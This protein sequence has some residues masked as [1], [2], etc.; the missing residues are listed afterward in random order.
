M[1]MQMNDS[2]EVYYLDEEKVKR[3]QTKL[4]DGLTATHL[5]QA[6]RALSDPS[7]V[8]IVS[9]LA[10]GE[11]CMCNIAATVGMSP[12]AVVQQLRALRSVGLV[13]YR[14]TG[15]EARYSLDSEHLVTLFA[16]G[17]SHLQEA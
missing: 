2:G 6:F 4:V 14:K 16:E 15:Q 17:L 1:S 7:R 10:S 8:R 12:S 11:M 5:A 13:Q 9:A 3:A